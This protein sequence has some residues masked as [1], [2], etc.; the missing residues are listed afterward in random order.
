MALILSLM[1]IAMLA[2]LGFAAVQ[3]STLAFSM[4]RGQIDLRIDIVCPKRANRRVV[5]TRYL[6]SC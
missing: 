2:T 3:Q 6:T 4:S 1:V 5:A